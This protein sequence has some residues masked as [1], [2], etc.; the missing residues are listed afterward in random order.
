MC[1]T[2]KKK[3]VQSESV[4]SCQTLLYWPSVEW[5]AFVRCFDTSWLQRLSHLQEN[6]PFSISLTD[7][8]HKKLDQ[9]WKTESFFVMVFFFFLSSIHAVERAVDVQRVTFFNKL[10]FVPCYKTPGRTLSPLPVRE[11]C[12]CVQ[13]G[14]KAFA[15]SIFFFS[16][17]T[18]YL[19]VLKWQE[20]S[21]PTWLVG[22]ADS[23]RF[24]GKYFWLC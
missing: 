6:K 7:I 23:H 17:I 18:F 16:A 3:K 14:W 5:R 1:W 4:P 20:N 12:I 13:F 15:S 10:Y 19:P 9:A 22:S 24:C 2:R 8:R 21:Q 11:L